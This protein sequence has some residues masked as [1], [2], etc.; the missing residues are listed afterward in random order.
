VF[1]AS[2]S[3]TGYYWDVPNGDILGNFA[4]M[5][6]EGS[7]PFILSPHLSDVPHLTMAHYIGDRGRNL[8]DA[9]VGLPPDS[10]AGFAAAAREKGMY[11]SL[12]NAYRSPEGVRIAAVAWENKL[13]Y[14]WDFKSDM[15]TQEYENELK[16]RKGEGFRPV[17][18]TSYA[19][20]ANPRYAASW[21]RYCYHPKPR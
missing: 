11:V 5:R 8:W 7:K 2:E 16:R 13:G 14:D 10:L 15:T 21:V 12:L 4:H 9:R 19:D 1:W 18:V 6:N 20:P 17:A 3:V